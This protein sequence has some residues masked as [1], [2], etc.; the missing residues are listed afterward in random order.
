[1]VQ[2]G[3]QGEV[4]EPTGRLRAEYGMITENV[5]RLVIG[6]AT[7]AREMRLQDGTPQGHPKCH[8][9]RSRKDG[10]PQ[11]VSNARLGGAANHGKTFPQHKNFKRTLSR[12]VAEWHKS[13][14]AW[15]SIEA[16]QTFWEQAAGGMGPEEGRSRH[17]RQDGSSTSHK[18]KTAASASAKPSGNGTPQPSWRTEAQRATKRA[19]G[20]HNKALRIPSP[21]RDRGKQACAHW[22]EDKGDR[23]MAR[24]VSQRMVSTSTN[25]SETGD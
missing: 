9:K 21:P 7:P 12:P 10:G 16:D 17:A 20:P 13:L 14:R 3:L 24:K 5:H 23:K 2:E 19:A 8:F 22:V 15:L 18:R 6:T 1:M 11:P 4:T 25:K